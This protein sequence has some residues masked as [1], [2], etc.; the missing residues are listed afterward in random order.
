MTFLKYKNRINLA[1]KSTSKLDF[2]LIKCKYKKEE[3]KNPVKPVYF[4][5]IYYSEYNWSVK[6][7]IKIIKAN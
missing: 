4:S 3:I 6:L 2:Y 1:L 5:H 7:H